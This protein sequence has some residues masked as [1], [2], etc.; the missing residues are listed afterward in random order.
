MLGL[1]AWEGKAEEPCRF[2]V[3]SLR[4]IGFDGAI[5]FG[6]A[7]GL[8][9]K[10]QAWLDRYRVTAHVVKTSKCARA[11]GGSTLCDSRDKITPVALA[12]FSWYREWLS[13]G[14][15]TGY[16]LLSD[17]RDVFFQANPFVGLQMDHRR[18]MLEFAAEFGWDAP[19]ERKIAVLAVAQSG[20][21][22]SPEAG[23]DHAL[24]LTNPSVS[25][26]SPCCARVGRLGRD[27][28]WTSTYN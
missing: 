21:V 16:I 2:F 27:L 22:A 3:R 13:K 1:A 9:D 20:R 25:P 28:V 7:A 12:R 10:E 17:V 6:V 24:D 4:K 15:Y 26:R 19:E 11:M 23:L 18:P 14:G 5:V 8:P